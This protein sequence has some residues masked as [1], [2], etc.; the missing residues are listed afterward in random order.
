VRLKGEGRKNCGN[1]AL[2]TSHQ[3]NKTKQNGMAGTAQCQ[4]D[5]HEEIDYHR[6]DVD[7]SGASEQEGIRLE[8]KRGGEF[9]GFQ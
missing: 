6:K 4:K 7:L 3:R 1:F 2:G 8:R 5:E 9:F